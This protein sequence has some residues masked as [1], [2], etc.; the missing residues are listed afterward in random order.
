MLARKQKDKEGLLYIKNGEKFI[1]K[2]RVIHGNLYDYSLVEYKGCQISVEII[3]PEH[4]IFKILPSSHLSGRGCQKCG[5]LLRIKKKTLT[6][7]KAISNMI[8]IH[9]DKYDYSLVEYINGYSKIKIICPIHGVFEQ[10]Y[11]DHFSGLGCSY[12]SNKKTH[13]LNCIGYKRPDLLKYFV[14][15]EDSKKYTEFSSKIV[16]V[17]CPNCGDI[18]TIRI[19]DM[20]TYGFNCHKC[21]DNIS[22]PEK[23]CYNLLKELEVDFTKEKVFNWS[24]N[25]RYDFYIPSLDMVIEVHGEQHYTQSFKSLG[26][27]SVEEEK[28][29][30]NYKENLAK[31]NGIKNYL[32]VDCRNSDLNW[33]KDNFIKRLSSYF[34]LENID[35]K[36]I[37][38]NSNKSIV[39][40]ICEQWNRYYKTHTT[41][42]LAELLKL[43]QSMIANSVKRGVSLGL[44]EYDKEI[45]RSKSA[46][47]ISKPV[48]QLDLDGNFVRELKSCR[49]GLIYG[50]DNSSISACCRGVRKVH[51]GFKF[52]YKENYM[53][54]MI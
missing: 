45:E 35:W 26:G 25:K 9:G 38:L 7:D 15:V 16:D 20:S 17:K 8:K 46:R 30:D 27:K 50:F 37:Y 13:E 53:G 39:V 18:R 42:D 1:E 11:N 22:L 52:V 21:N 23:F 12:C 5:E 43:N 14:D 28:V 40:Y 54:G 36:N 4:G 3:C 29:N 31:L 2:A 48:I 33:L 19:S 24:E 32:I 6:Q 41:K 47:K 10:T 51:K 44:C 49:E 34:N